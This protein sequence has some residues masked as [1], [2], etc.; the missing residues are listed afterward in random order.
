MGLLGWVLAVVL[1]AWSGGR[2]YGVDWSPM[3]GTGPDFEFHGFASQGFLGTSHYNYLGDTKGGSLEF[4]EMGLNVSFNPFPRTLI[5]AQAFDYDVGNAGR[6]DAVLDYALAQYTFNNYLGIRGGRLRRP[7]GIY[8]DTQDVDLGRTFILLPQGMYDARYRDFYVS[9]DGGDIFGTLPLGRAGSLDYELY[10]GQVRPSTD[11][12]VALQVDNGLPPGGQL[13][14]IASATIAGGQLW[15]ETPVSGLRLGLAGGAIPD[16]RIASTLDTPVGK[17]P[18]E[19]EGKINFQHVSV[20]YQVKRWTL[21]SELFFQNYESLRAPLGNTESFSWY[22]SAEYRVNK[23]L[24][25]GSYYTEYYNDLGN[26]SGRGLSAKSDAAQKD[27]A[28][29]VR[30]D[31][32]SR[33]E[34]KVEGHYMRGT[35]LLQDNSQNP[36]RTNDAWWMIAVKST[37]SF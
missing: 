17:L 31:L 32:T 29:A 37:I 33:W 13:D 4:T 34:C 23:W 15:W 1:M 35:A 26:M 16:F 10:G 36:N 8:N 25:V 24:G 20:Q 5:M 30:V 21:Q 19:Q 27:L 6:Y 14:S 18:L 3:G 28:V 11:G 9:L 22:A 2:T 7:Q 12:G